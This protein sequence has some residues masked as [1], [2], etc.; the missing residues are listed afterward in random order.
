MS[1]HQLNSTNLFHEMYNY[2]NVLQCI[3]PIFIWSVTWDSSTGV[4]KVLIKGLF[5]T[6][7]YFIMFWG[8]RARRQD[9]FINIS[10]LATSP[11]KEN[12]DSSIPDVYRWK[13]KVTESLNGLPM[14]CELN[15]KAFDSSSYL[16][17]FTANNAW[18]FTICYLSL[19]GSFSPLW[20]WNHQ[21]LKINK[22]LLFE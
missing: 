1:H 15:R 22:H 21:T 10:F 17:L 14:T 9:C 18:T 4:P 12:Q 13:N 2:W 3:K 20:R 19:L 6:E 16:T 7:S 5:P 8:S 11:W